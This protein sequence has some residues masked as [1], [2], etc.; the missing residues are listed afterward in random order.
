MMGKVKAKTNTISHLLGVPVSV[1]EQTTRFA[2]A[3][4]AYDIAT[5]PGVLD[6]AN[7]VLAKDNRWQAFKA[8]KNKTYLTEQEKFALFIMDEAHAVFGKLGRVEY[9]RSIGGALVFPFM[10]YPHQMLELMG[11]LYGRGVDGRRGLMVTLTALFLISGLMGLPGAEMLKEML[12]ALEKQFT[13]S[14]EDIDLLIR[15]KMYAM[16]GSPTF[17]KFLTQGVGRS[18]FGMDISKRVGLPVPGQEIAFAMTG[19][20]GDATSILGVQGSLITSLATAFKEWNSDSGV[21]PVAAA[22]TPVAFANLLK[23]YQYTEDGVDTQRGTKLLTADEVTAKTVISRALGVTTDQIATQREKQ[24]YKLLL[25]NKH[26][27][28]VDSFREQAKDAKAKE[29]R[30]QKKGDFTEVK[31]QQERR[32]EV[33]QKLVDYHREHEMPIDLIAFNRSV[34]KDALQRNDPAMKLKD[35]RKA[36]RKEVSKMLEVLGTE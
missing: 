19:V 22:L 30:A 27:P 18:L 12:E 23:A 20:R 10:T 2:T 6:Q 26:K 34:V 24:Y 35:V 16:T 13:G 5:M 9:Q 33:Y 32:K 25:E 11:R 36:A 7:K 29:M 14:E 8:D 15:E 17:G 28:K 31:K 4:S 3:M 21:V 1:A